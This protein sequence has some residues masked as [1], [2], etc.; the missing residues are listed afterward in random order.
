MMLSK[1]HTNSTSTI[2]TL[3]SRWNMHGRSSVMTKNSVVLTALKIL[4]V[5]EIQKEQNWMK[6]AHF[7]QALTQKSSKRKGKKVVTKTTHQER[8]SNSRSRLEN[9]WALKEKDIAEIKKLTK[10]ELLKSLLEKTEQ[11]SE[12]EETLKNKIIDEMFEFI[13]KNF[14]DGVIS[15][16]GEDYLR[17]PTAEDLKRLLDIGEMRGFP[18]MIGNIDCMHR[19][20]KNCPTAWKGKYSRGSGKL[21]IV[22]EVVASHDL[23]IWHAFFG[24]PVSHRWYIS[25]VGYIYP[26]N[27]TSPRSEIIVIVGVENGCNEVNVKISEE[28]NV[29]NFF[30]KY[31]FEIDSS[32]RKALRKKR[33]SSDKS[34]KRVATQKPNT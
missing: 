15:L 33:E 1:L 7:L 6:L 17:R 20:W 16:F 29:E 3:N 24:P 26:I 9:L 30:D 28:E 34:S 32:L 12:K 10:T 13:L 11:L 14:V 4:R 27:S 19:E 5:V 25:K 2:T 22:L 21:T 18:G 23:W 31:F 8:K